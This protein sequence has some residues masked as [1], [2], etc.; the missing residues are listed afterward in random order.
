[1]HVCVR[2]RECRHVSVYACACTR[3]CVCTH[4]CMCVRACLCMPV[5]V[6]VRMHVCHSTF[7]EVQGLCS[8][9]SPHLGPDVTVSSAAH[10]ML[11]GLQASG[12]S[13][14]C[15]TVQL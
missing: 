6:S 12:S 1:M 4:E 7:V 14:F 3:A 9:Q 8:P 10:A 11:A 13:G 15:L 5:C 2:V